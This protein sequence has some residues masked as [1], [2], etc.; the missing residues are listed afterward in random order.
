MVD[1][2]G[3]FAMALL[4]ATPAWIIWGGRGA[5]AFTAF[6]LVTAMLPDVDLVLRHFVPVSHHGVT[7]TLLFVVVVSSII[8][9]ISARYLTSYLNAH[10]RIRSTRISRETV[11][12]FATAGFIIGGVSHIFADLLSAPDI[13]APLAPFWPIYRQHIVIDVIYYDSPIWNFG[14]LG[15]AVALHYLLARHKRYPLHTRYRIGDPKKG[16]KS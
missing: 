16:N 15:V 7:H 9:A 4:F 14:L 13:A 6:T 8:G 11:F 1:V 2:S 12:V 10:S 5:L 3:H